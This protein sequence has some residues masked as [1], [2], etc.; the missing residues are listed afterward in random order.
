MRA[1]AYGKTTGDG[2]AARNERGESGMN[3]KPGRGPRAAV[4]AGAA[5]LLLT[6]CGS[7][8]TAG[9]TPEGWGTL[10]TERLTVAH[11]AAFEEVV[12]DKG[13]AHEVARATLTEGGV[14]AAAMSVEFDHGSL[15]TVEMAAVGAEARIQLGATPAG[16]TEIRVAGPGGRAEARKI[17][18]AFTS[19]GGPGTPPG[20]TRLEGLM[21]TGVD[22]RSRPYLITVN[23][24]AGALSDRDVTEIVESV[25]LTVPEK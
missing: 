5:G 11:P 9:T 8:G 3:G 19:R 7:G 12:P 20:G 23:S 16:T 15:H 24:R 1:D 18:Y 10:R 13:N 21:V 6:A 25:T 14:L 4:A 2:N 17:T 22:A